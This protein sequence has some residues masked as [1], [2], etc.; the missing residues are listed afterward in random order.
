MHKQNELGL[1]EKSAPETNRE[2]NRPPVRTALLREKGKE[3]PRAP[4]ESLDS[5]VV[6]LHEA[7][8]KILR[9]I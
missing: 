9:R 3:T 5:N 1:E 2:E 4:S 8:V 7:V 6:S